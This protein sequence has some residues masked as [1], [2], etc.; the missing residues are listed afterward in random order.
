MHL[1][2]ASYRFETTSRHENDFRRLFGLLA[3]ISIGCFFNFGTFHEEGRF[4]HEHEQ[5]H[6]FLGSK[7]LRDPQTFKLTNH[8]IAPERETQLR[9]RF[10][11]ERRSNFAQTPPGSVTP[12][13]T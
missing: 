11:P 13:R 6:F 2:F 1:L 3:V 10:T 12:A 8:E 7:Y 4:V 9:E 5:Y